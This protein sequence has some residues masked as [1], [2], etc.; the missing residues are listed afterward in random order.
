MDNKGTNNNKVPYWK[1]AIKI[2]SAVSAWIVFPVILAVIFGKIL[3]NHFNTKPVIFL[4]CTGV[5]FLLSCY[6][7]FRVVK[8]YTKNLKN[9]NNN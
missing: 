7:I 4:F 9:K 1:P 8:S 3:D 2:F 6:G 5:S